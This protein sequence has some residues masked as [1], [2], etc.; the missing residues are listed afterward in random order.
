[1]TGTAAIYTRISKDPEG[2]ELGVQRQE[3]DC[4]ALAERLGYDSVLVFQDN[5]VSASTL[6]DKP[7]PAFVQMMDAAK[8]GEV[9]GIISYSNSRLTRRVAEIQAIIDVT[10]RTGIRVHTVASG[11]HDLDTADGRGNMLTIAV[12]DQVE[13]E[14]TSERIKR[15]KQQ[16]AERGEWHGGAAPFGYR[17]KDKRLT[18][19]PREVAMI[20]EAAR[21]ILTGDSL[22]SI[23]TEW[24][25]P[26]GEVV[27]VWHPRRREFVDVPAV[28]KPTRSGAHWRQSNLR[29]ILMNRSLLGETKAGVVGW[30]PIIEQ[31]TFDR[32]Q[33]VFTDPSRK[34]THSPGVKSSKY[35]MGGGVTI[36]G[37]CGY[38]LITGLK[39]GRPILQCRKVVSG[40]GACG[41]VVVDHKRLE[42]Y[43]FGEVVAALTKDTRLSQRLA[44]RGEDV[45][46][47]IA[48]LEAERDDLVDKQRRLH[49]LYLDGDLDQKYHREKVAELKVAAAEVRRKIDDF[50]GRPLLSDAMAGGLDWESWSSDKRRNFLR[51]AGVGVKVDPWPLGMQRNVFPRKGESAESL[52]KRREEI[53]R[54]VIEQ[55]TTVTAA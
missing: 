35:S 27:T 32:L 55:R 17:A 12:W 16:K 21:R 54:A 46:S 6:S 42:E 22:H 30:E 13:A 3:A 44:E 40:P 38:R 53:Q 52:A 39:R 47:K 7:R 29:S 5:D 11:Q 34:V 9:A 14:R 4:R 20:E 37:R 43:V 25:K 24:N 10:K 2:R 19:E 23:V 18:P 48:A 1:M 28:M 45:D 15:Q 26:T 33:R 41:G 36:C 8:R 31:R 49:D 51:V 50:L